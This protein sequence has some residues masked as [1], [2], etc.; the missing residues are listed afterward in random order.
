MNNRML[1][2]L[3]VVF[4]LGTAYAGMD[5]IGGWHAVGSDNSCFVSNAASQILAEPMVLSTME[6]GGSV[7]PEMAI[8]EAIRSQAAALNNDPVEI[9]EFVRN[10]IGYELYYGCFKG[11][12][13]TLLSGFGNDLDQCALLGSLLKVADDSIDVSYVRGNVIYTGEF[14]TNLTGCPTNHFQHLNPWFLIHAPVQRADGWE[15]D[16]HYWLQAEIDGTT[17]QLDPSFVPHESAPEDAETVLAQVT[18]YTRTNFLSTA[19]NG[20]TVFTSE[21]VQNVNETAV[22]NLLRGYV[23]QVHQ[24]QNDG[25]SEVEQ[26]VG[27]RMPQSEPLSV[28]STNLPPDMVR[29]ASSSV[30]G[31]LPDNMFARYELTHESGF[32]SVALK[33]YELAG[34]RITIFYDSDDGN[35][36][37]LR[38]DGEEKARGTTAL[39]VGYVK[40]LTLKVLLPSFFG[41]YEKANAN[42]PCDLTV[43]YSYSVVSDLLMASPKVLARE[44]RKLAAFRSQGLSDASE[45]VLGTTLHL[46]NLF[47]CRQNTLQNKLLSRLTGIPS[48]GLFQGGVVAQEEGYYIDLPLLG[49]S[50][51]MQMPDSS[52]L[53]QASSFM[54][55]GLE[56]GMLEQIMGPERPGISS[57]KG[58][59]LNN[60]NGKHTYYAT[61]ANW[62]SGLNVKSKLSGYTPAQK[63]DL[64]TEINKG[65]RMVLPRNAVTVG[66]W[67]G[68]TYFKVYS[69]ALGA[70]ISGA[71]GT[72][73]GGYSGYQGYVPPPV[74]NTVTRT[75]YIPP[76]PP[77]IQLF[78]PKSIEPVDL[79]SGDYLLDHKD[80]TLSGPLPLILN[81]HYNSGQVAADGVM[82]PGWCHSLQIE[83]DE[84]SSGDFAFGERDTADAAAV[85]AAQMIALDLMR[86]E[87]NAKGWTTAAIA[88]KWALDS[89][90]EN[91]ITV[92]IGESGR[93]FT[94]LPDGEFN[95]PPG[96]TD[97]LI[98]TNGVYILQERNANKYT[99][100]TNNLIAEIADTDGNT[101]TFTYNA[102]TNL[103]S[104]VSSFGPT[105]SFSY[106]G[107][108]LT[109]VSDN[110]TPTRTIQYQYD[111]SDNLTNFVDAVG[112]DW[113]IAYSD[114]NHPSA[115]TSLTDPEG[116]TTIQN[117]YNS[118]GVV[119]QQISATSNIWK[120]HTSNAQSIE[121]DPAGRKTIYRFDLK[122]R[123]VETQAADGNSTFRRYNERDQ[124]TNSVNAAGV[125]NL[126][127]YDNSL[128]LV[129]KRESAGT[130]EERVSVYGYDASNRLV[131]ISNQ[132]S[133]T[134]WQVSR[135]EY[136]SE[137]HVTKTTD[138]LSNETT[139]VYY[140]SG[141]LQQKS[142]GNGLRVTSYTYDS[143]GNPDTV[144]STDSGTN[145]FLYNARGE[146]LQH[147]DSRGQ[148]TETT[149]DASGNLLLTE[150]SDGTTV[151]NSYWN[152]GLLK[153]VTDARGHTTHYTYTPAY[154]QKTITAPDG[155]VVSN[156]YDA[157]DRLV[158]VTDAKGNV[159]SNLLDDVGRTIASYSTLTTRQFA[160][161]KAGNITNS[162]IDPSG[163]NL[164]DHTAYDDFSRPVSKSTPLATETFQYDPL[165]RMTNR[166]DQ[167]SKHWK[168]EFDPLSRPIASVRPSGAREESDYN[169][170][171]FRT[172]FR[173]AEGNVISFGV[174][175][176]SR[177]TSITNAIGNVT[178]YQFDNNGNLTNRTDAAGRSTAYIFDGMNRI[179]R[180]EYP[181]MTQSV[182]DHDAS[183]NLILS[184]NENA[185]ITFAYDTMNR[186]SEADVSL[187]SLSS[188]A[189]TNSCDLNGNRTNILYPG[190]LSVSYSFDEEN[191]L[192]SV[193]ANHANFANEFSFG[194]DGASRLTN[195]VYPNSVVSA[196]E[197]DAENR[198]VGFTHGTFCEHAIQRDVRGFKIR[199]DIYEGLVPNFTNNLHQTLTH[200][201]ADQLVSDGL[202]SYAYNNNG[203]LTNTAGAEYQ[204]DYND[205][206]TSVNGTEYLYDASGARIGRIWG[207]VTNYFILD[208][209]APLKMP[210]A[211]ANADG[212]ITRYYVWSSHGLLAHFDRNPATGAITSTRYYHANEQKSV[213]AL[214]DETGSVTDRFAYSP[215]GQVLGRTG[216]TDTPY[217]WI[218]GLAVRNEGG[219]LYF[220]LNRYYSADVRRFLS[221]DPAG[222]DSFPNL[223]AYADINPL[224]FVDPL[225][226]WQ[227]TIGAAYG[228][229]GRVTFGKN[230]GRWNVGGAVGYGLG[231]MI[232][233]APGNSAPAFASQGEASHV[234]VEVSGGAKL[235]NALDVSGGLRVR[236][237]A[238]D[239]TN[240]EG[241]GGLIGSLTIPGTIINAN[242][243][244]DVVV[245][246]N[247]SQKT[248]D[249]FLEASPEPTSFG[250]GAMVFGGITG[251]TSW[252]SKPPQGSSPSTT[253]GHTTTGY[254]K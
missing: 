163:L 99:F 223:Y 11:A 42:K 227:V 240:V 20:A 115:I 197:Y 146:L 168:T 47:Y 87:D 110:S 8:T 219:G 79:Y 72:Q 29:V 222:I 166:I 202:D 12:E 145:D 187:R 116:I 5:S 111:S 161:D 106:T 95:P 4:S 69:Q 254:L 196:F 188:F 68:I 18:G 61:S 36:P 148:T 9:F 101:L 253:H 140:P 19:S 173:N 112:F 2:I 234:G 53:F 214:T 143:Y 216:T 179:D 108:L 162:V 51:V 65:Y 39:T 204:W 139:F 213:L 7:L 16:K 218:G 142:E 97:K 105:L 93:Q 248:S 155:G 103:Q 194:Y 13:G 83:I 15:F 152:N 10:R 205:H 185:E 246:G 170:L 135:F 232:D 85:L 44:S 224:A 46:M 221:I 178:R 183:G 1:T 122:G 230:N 119:T 67:T 94:R 243:S 159:V 6:S 41:M 186:L 192:E 208:Y 195:I 129:E 217:Q 157:A 117:F 184:S 75:T 45:E 55:S 104:V 229:G 22:E 37:V 109:S 126:L 233:F 128:N 164:W 154:K 167:I 220:M 78:R 250:F 199:E 209:H 215:Y 131:C 207:G 52:S 98:Q 70:I 189:V 54:A 156:A 175:A 251:G 153:T 137:H 102:Q 127:V 200:N 198:I 124:V 226:L 62:T 31:S 71:Y 17:Y 121:E 14:L 191:R 160:Y 21:Q 133:A 64:G 212:S 210:L 3:G 225:G 201:D 141:L 56:H 48:L 193:T 96:S 138:A 203:C 144:I 32:S 76:P 165:G 237:D 252:Q 182:F 136:D 151:S 88:A 91:T 60:A 245:Q 113:G 242:G 244:A 40:N 239:A 147:T 181:D 134:E 34:K 180:V 231:A 89:A 169:A 84:H 28:L 236:V 238:D 114:T 23:A 30:L 206:L 59:A 228:Y 49:M 27:Q 58:I 149:Y 172:Q 100:N 247:I 123:T 211:E 25:D 150:F 35:R 249:S 43:G 57:T 63:T 176:Q 241:R 38:L 130:S 174:D 73:N 120:F 125:T 235:L 90:V 24:A 158:S 66:N 77:P 107:G 171:S 26:L 118:L 50:Y 190:G 92:R 81:R 33:G 132:L 177:V 86:N 80:L 74:V 82:G